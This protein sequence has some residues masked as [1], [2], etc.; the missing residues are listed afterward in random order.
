VPGYRFYG[1]RSAQEE[2]CV[3]LTDTQQAA[4]QTG[5]S[6]ISDFSRYRALALDIDGTLLRSDHTLSPHVAAAIRTLAGHGIAVFL[7]S[8]RPPKSVGLLARAIGL[9]GPFVALNGAFIGSAGQILQQH[10]IDADS[11]STLVALCHRQGD[12]LLS[13]YSGWAWYVTTHDL[14][15]QAESGIVGFGPDGVWPPRAAKVPPVGKVLVMADERRSEKLAQVIAALPDSL[16]GS[17]SK[18][19]YLEITGK[20][21]SKIGALEM[22]MARRGWSLE[23]LMTVGDGDNDLPMVQHA[24]LGIAMGNGTDKIKRCAQVVIGLNDEDGL[25]ELLNPWNDFLAR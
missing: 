23:V 12:L 2:D 16:D 1:E 5:T 11:L 9:S 15:V 10:S 4:V 3:L 19:G 8:A 21:V 13:L 25:L 22:L 17:M 18:P 14:C 20:G 6:V 24:G 7:T